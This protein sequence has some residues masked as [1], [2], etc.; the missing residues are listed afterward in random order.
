M[1]GKSRK[2]QRHPS[3]PAQK[4]GELSAKMFKQAVDF[5]RKGD[6]VQAMAFY[7]RTISR[8]PA[9]A[10][11]HNNLGVIL[12]ALGKYEEALASF[13]RASTVK[14]DYIAAHNN[15]GNILK[16]L[17]R[18]E[19]ALAS[20]DRSI[21]LNPDHEAYNNR[22][23]LLERFQRY[24]EAL[25]AYDQAIALNPDHADAYWNKS[26]LFLSTGNYEKGWMLYEW[27]W[28]R[29]KYKTL[30]SRYVKPLWIGD[31]DVRGKTILIHQEQ[32]LGDTIQMMRYVPMLSEQGAKVVLKVKD[33]LLPLM[34]DLPGVE[35]VMK[36]EEPLPDYDLHCPFMSL[37]L[38]FK[39]TLETI[40]TSLPY[41]KAPESKSIYWKARLGDKILPRVGM[42]WSGAAGHANDR[43][44]SVPLPKILPLLSCGAEFH[45]LQKEYR[46]A[47]RKLVIHEERIKDH[48]Y[49]LA[50]FSDTAALIEEM[51]LVI[52]VDTAVAHLAGALGKPVWIILPHTADYR[53]MADR[54]DSP[55]YPT[56]Q[57]FRQPAF[58]DWDTVIEKMVVS[59]DNLYQV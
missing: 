24:D 23:D 14:P 57:L 45:S 20:Y 16:T 2:H 13:V 21:A 31:A 4:G 56:A 50:D 49:D 27:R 52:S 36:Q 47:D 48:C 44:R 33:N 17:G 22:G 34:K 39:T 18:Y 46:D 5:H 6:T 28:Q 11:A 55:W 30:S 37:P 43:N 58:N 35:C 3:P 26:L 10:E 40:P 51:D 42:A 12:Q 25:E 59:F 8:F 29:E 19:E 32:G 9:F 1:K 53:W 7:K 41:L 38:A 15:G 54:Q